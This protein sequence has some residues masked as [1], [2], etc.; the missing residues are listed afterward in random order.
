MKKPSITCLAIIAILSDCCPAYGMECILQENDKSSNENMRFENLKPHEPS[1]CELSED[2][3]SPSISASNYNLDEYNNN[4]DNSNSNANSCNDELIDQSQ[5]ETKLPKRNQISTKKRRNSF[6]YSSYSVT[7]NHTATAVSY[8]LLG[9][10]NFEHVKNQRRKGCFNLALCSSPEQKNKEESE[11]NIIDIRRH[12]TSRRG[13][14]TSNSSM[15]LLPVLTQ[16]LEPIDSQVFNFIKYQQQSNENSSMSILQVATQSTEIVPFDSERF[17]SIKYSK[18]NTQ[19]SSEKSADLPRY[20]HVQPKRPVKVVVTIDGGGSRGIIPLFLLR[21]MRRELGLKSGEALPV[22]MFVGTSVGA[23]VATA[24]IL[25]KLDE[26]YSNFTNLVQTIFPEQWWLKKFARLLWYGY[27]YPSEGREKAIDEFLT[28]EMEEFIDAGINVP[29]LV[30]P[31]FSAATR[32]IFYYDN[33]EHKNGQTEYSVRDVL[34]ATSAAPFFFGQYKIIGRDG[35]VI[36]ASDGG[37]HANHP[38]IIA[39]QKATIRWPG[40]LIKMISIGT[41]AGMQES[42]ST[43]YFG[44]VDWI[45][46]L[47]SIFMDLQRGSCNHFLKELS[48]SHPELLKYIRINFF[49]KECST[50]DSSHEAIANYEAMARYAVSPDGTEHE[51]LKESVKVMRENIN[52]AASQDEIE[53]EDLHIAA[54]PMRGNQNPKSNRRSMDR[55]MW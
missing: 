49:L 33:Y 50:D 18:R 5:F 7:T 37:V 38:G 51:D 46:E 1:L 21:K 55:T 52:L 26:L 17:N 24:A 8:Q 2:S 28:P 47:V 11:E 29:N 10:P 30:I 22:D 27:M 19:E 23:I 35:V 40:A 14:I 54:G 36:M 45:K 39:W 20:R 53:Q 48:H 16:N 9:K 4:D 43:K 6:D 15:P 41:G 31:F 32:E 42:K 12:S 44:F 25:G 3:V 13:S 34:K